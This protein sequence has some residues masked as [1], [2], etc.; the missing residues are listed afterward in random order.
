MVGS[1]T[2]NGPSGEDAVL[3]DVTA[4]KITM[5]RIHPGVFTDITAEDVSLTG[6]AITTQLVEMD[7]FDIDAFTVAGCGWRM[8]MADS[9]LESF[10]STCSSSSSKNTV[11]IK[12]SDFTHGSSSEHVIDGRNTFVSVGESSITSTSVSASGSQVAKARSGTDIVLISMDLN[13]N[14]CSDS[15]GDTG[16]CAYDVSRLRPR[17]RPWCTSVAWPMRLFT[18]RPQPPVCTS[19]ATL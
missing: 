8:Q 19:P 5:Q 15:N 10:K 18:D 1:Q 7:N 2:G 17:T 3:N 11:T 4:G 12:D 14:D 6:T 13:G 9:T 16:N